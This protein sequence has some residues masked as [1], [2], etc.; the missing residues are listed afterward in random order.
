MQIWELNTLDVGL[1]TFY[2][3]EKD[4][5]ESFNHLVNLAI[6]SSQSIAEKWE[7]L[8]LLKEE[9]KIDSDFFDLYDTGVLVVSLDAAATLKLSIPEVD[10]ELLPFMNDENKYFL[11]NLLK[12][13]DCLN[14]KESIYEC[15]D[16]GI[17]STFETLIF[18]CEKIK[19]IPVFKIPE[20]PYTLFVTNVFE[21]LC[22]FQNLIGID[23]SE[24]EIIFV[25]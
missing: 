21:Y 22:D 23:F 24:D 14:K 15:F 9:Q 6:D 12:S 10:Y 8:V 2:L 1:T 11:F 19:D 20:L 25:N 13:T 18:D 17:I 16:N 3:P 5:I 4:K 7:P